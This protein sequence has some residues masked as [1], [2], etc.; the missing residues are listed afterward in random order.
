MY[1]HTLNEPDGPYAYLDKMQAAVDACRAAESRNFDLDDI[2]DL[3]AAARQLAAIR[4]SSGLTAEDRAE[5]HNPPRCYD[6]NDQTFTY[7][8]P[9][10]AERILAAHDSLALRLAE[11]Q[12]AVAALG[13]KCSGLENDREY[14]AGLLAEAEKEYR[15]LWCA[16]WCAPIEEYQRFDQPSE[17][18]GATHEET[19]KEAGRQATRRLGVP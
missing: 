7:V 8:A 6:D 3:I 12:S 15:E 18:G 1:H 16:I 13:R 11:E 17:D 4:E 9:E 10:V 14:N 5:V 2:D 19:C